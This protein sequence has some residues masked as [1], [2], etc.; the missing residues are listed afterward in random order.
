[1]TPCY[2][3]KWLHSLSS[4]VLFGTGLGTAFQ[5]V[6]AMRTG[7]VETIANVAAA[8]VLADLI[9]TLPAGIIQP[10]TGLR[11]IKKVRYSPTR[12]WLIAAYTNGRRG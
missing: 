12:P 3:A 7:R 6:R 9:F 4:T 11:L 2:I 10:L 8:V 1:M 5:M